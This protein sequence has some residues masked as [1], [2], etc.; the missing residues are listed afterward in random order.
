MNSRGLL[1]SNRLRSMSSMTEKRSAELNP[2][3]QANCC[4]GKSGSPIA[5]NRKGSGGSAGGIQPLTVYPP[6]GDCGC[7]D[8]APQ[9]A[10]SLQSLH[11]LPMAG[12][13]EP[14]DEPCCGPPQSPPAVPY[15][16]A[17]YRICPFV[18][19]FKGTS[20]WCRG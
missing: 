14:D 4:A 11:I 9:E 1:I 16:K 7:G 12:V 20:V 3:E 5:V 17:G 13:R 15:E 8:N 18:Q 10:G 6:R 2:K 19:G